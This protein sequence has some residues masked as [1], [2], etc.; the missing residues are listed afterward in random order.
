MEIKNQWGV[1]ESLW[2]NYAK[3]P[4]LTG[5][6]LNF[7]KPPPDTSSQRSSELSE[8]L[9]SVT[10]Y[11]LMAMDDETSD[12]EMTPSKYNANTI[13]STTRPQTGNATSK[14]ASN[15][16]T[17]ASTTTARG[18]QG[19]GGKKAT[20]TAP[21]TGTASLPA[22]AAASAIREKP[23]LS[24]ATVKRMERNVNQAL[25]QSST[26]V[27][28]KPRITGPSSST[29]VNT[30]LKPYLKRVQLKKTSMT[31]DD[32]N[33]KIDDD[34]QDDDEDDGNVEEL[35][36]TKKVKVRQ[37]DKIWGY[38]WLGH[39]VPCPFEARP[40]LSHLMY[41]ENKS[42]FGDPISMNLPSLHELPDEDM[43][44][45]LMKVKNIVKDLFDKKQKRFKDEAMAELNEIR[46][47]ILDIYTRYGI[48]WSFPDETEE[49]RIK[50]ENRV[51]QR[52]NRKALAEKKA[53]EKEMVGSEDDES[54]TEE[55]N[56]K[57]SQ[58][59]LVGGMPL[60]D[61]SKLTGIPPEKLLL[62][63]EGM[64][65][66]MIWL[67][68][69][70]LEEEDRL[71]LTKE[72]EDSNER[73]VQRTQVLLEA[74]RWLQG[75]GI[76]LTNP[77]IDCPYNDVAQNEMHARHHAHNGVNHNIFGRVSK[78]VAKTV[79]M[80]I[81]I[82]QQYFDWQPAAHKASDASSGKSSGD[83]NVHRLVADEAQR[84]P[85]TI[86]R[87]EDGDKKLAITL[88][89]EV[90]SL[91]AP[92]GF[93]TDEE[94]IVNADNWEVAVNS[95]EKQ[96]KNA[97]ELTYC[98]KGR[99][100]VEQ[101]RKQA[102][103][104][105]RTFEQQLSVITQR[106][107][108]LD[109]LQSTLR[110]LQLEL[111]DVKQYHRLRENVIKEK[112]GDSD[113]WGF[114]VKELEHT[115]ATFL[116]TIQMFDM[117]YRAAVPK[118]AKKI[119]E[120]MKYTS[121]ITNEGQAKVKEKSEMNAFTAIA[122]SVK[123]LDNKMTNTLIEFQEEQRQRQTVLRG[124]IDAAGKKK[125]IGFPPQ[126]PPT[127]DYSVIEPKSPEPKTRGRSPRSG[128]SKKSG[129]NK[130]ATLKN[131]RNKNYNEDDD[132]DAEHML[133]ESH[134]WLGDAHNR[135]T[136][137]QTLGVL[138]RRR[139][140]VVGTA[141]SSIASV[142]QRHGM[143]GG[144]KHSVVSDK[145]EPFSPRMTPIPTNEKKTYFPSIDKKYLNYL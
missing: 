114:R 76:D 134:S 93:F 40:E 7:K 90:Q 128:R 113:L 75:L 91:C 136:P 12:E 27:N 101:C 73:A 120:A 67:Q 84:S 21:M 65:D 41:W 107:A 8:L 97:M 105:K 118:I 57:M 129:K 36:K 1:N 18:S 2:E 26:N 133:R 79:I 37:K 9:S 122:N 111:Y 140:S 96:F 77:N 88:T 38:D 33:K 81:Y 42:H 110:T 121:H 3:H 23:F 49:E 74:N 52:L 106:G 141:R 62:M 51:Q 50:R 19:E 72:I 100:K 24:T 45:G 59:V 87:E 112:A 53:S 66:L 11:S 48:N 17:G 58:P 86:L 28:S 31:G 5:G 145:F 95:L 34:L 131:Q 99:E 115:V 47:R 137:D 83:D 30:A 132:S 35:K 68:R 125:S 63:S 85:S 102:F 43:D 109:E 117:E 144:A 13:K 104:I 60:Q 116:R 124:R 16:K 6:A 70:A 78:L 82:L 56:V 142:S 71:Q 92:K 94:L 14:T 55:C 15:T 10:K 4:N 46:G 61:A 139:Q 143:T 103:C 130:N 32:A 80:G 119:G 89:K 29:A 108:E 44:P 54:E 25:T 22:A 39:P 69:K 20:V 138:N 98:K 135:R 123:E 127:T 126:P 64:Q